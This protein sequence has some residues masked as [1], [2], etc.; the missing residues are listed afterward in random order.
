M[1]F[2]VSNVKDFWIV[3][4][5]TLLYLMLVSFI[6]PVVVG[7]IGELHSPNFFESRL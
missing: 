6:S 3:V 1:G 2:K 5:E 4:W 7:F